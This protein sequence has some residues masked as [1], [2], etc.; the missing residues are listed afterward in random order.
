MDNAAI[1]RAKDH[2]AKILEAQMK[3]MERIKSA[4]GWV[5]YSKVKPIR[6]GIIGGDGIGPFIAKNAKHV[7]GFMLR[8]EAESGRV[9]V[10]DIEGLTSSTAPPA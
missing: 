6:I 7:L 1:E 2:F 3:R 4:P 10:N 5:D 8:D 9:V